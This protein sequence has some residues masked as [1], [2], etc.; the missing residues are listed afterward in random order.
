MSAGATSMR[1]NFAVMADAHLGEAEVA[2]EILRLF[3]RAEFF[4]RDGGAVGDARGQ[5][6]EGRFIPGAQAQLTR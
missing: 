1:A 6:G 2:Q 4:A 5:A 3:H